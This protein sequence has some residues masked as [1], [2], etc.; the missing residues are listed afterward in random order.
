MRKPFSRTR[1]G[2]AANGN[3]GPVRIGGDPPSRV[4]IRA[5][6]LLA[7]LTLLAHSPA[8]QAGW[9]WD[10]DDYVTE[11]PTLRTADGLG[12][13]WFEPGAIPQYYPLVHTTYWLEYRLWG[14][15]PMGF[16]LVNV[17]LHFGVSLLLLRV[18]RL[19]EVPGALLASVAFA[20][21]PVGVE[22]V[23]W[24]TERKNLLS[25]IF[26]LLALD[27]Y[28]RYEGFGAGAPARGRH[29]LY[30]ASLAAFLAALLSKTVAAT[31]PAAV[32]LILWWK[33]GWIRRGDLWR[34]IPFFVLGAAL[35]IVTLT[36][37]TRH[38]GAQGTDFEF[39]PIERIAI[40]GRALWFYLG[41]I[42]FPVQLAF[43]YPRWP[44]ESRAVPAL[45]PGLAFL[46]L[47]ASAIGVRH[48]IGRGPAA[49]LLF[50]AGTLVPALGFFNVYP[51]RYSF[52]A[53]HF[54]Y[55]ASGSILALIA[56][57]GGTLARSAP[58][59]VRPWIVASSIVWVGVLG[60]LCVQRSLVFRSEESTWVDTLR[61]NPSCWMAHHNLAMIE[62]GRGDTAS[63]IRRYQS[64]LAVRDDLPQTHFNLGN[65][66][67][68]SGNW[69]GAQDAFEES[70]RYSPGYADA[71]VAL[72]NVLFSRGDR[73]GAVACWNRALAIDPGNEAAQRNLRTAGTRDKAR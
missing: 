35:G 19:L 12:R 39:L 20:V 31:L 3:P 24:V 72:G 54:Q 62:E 22:T 69:A 55:L 52:V 5:L 10:D 37:E 58:R 44:V 67:A 7:V 40:A 27:S 9:I 36:I 71:H 47:V 56:C 14:L 23:A 65:A 63:A 33:R 11:N 34:S 53:D 42:V 15:R 4:R 50:F 6:L 41:K 61:K 30:A 18:L 57:A 17:L 64:A 59:S 51:M 2:S 66:L 26:Y 32:L 38:V 8:L 48:R 28:L 73:D 29:A 21:H 60:L 1:S 46:A 13:I 16:H 70:I 45:L 68:R 43:I 25:A 49:A